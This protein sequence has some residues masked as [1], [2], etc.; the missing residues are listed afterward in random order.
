[1]HWFTNVVLLRK[2]T[3]ITA[4][5]CVLEKWVVVIRDDIPSALLCIG[6]SIMYKGATG[7]QNGEC[8]ETFQRY[9]HPQEYRRGSKRIHIRW[10]GK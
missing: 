5:V 1:M 2:K 6:Q 9:R 10:T 3:E 7:E 8:R 4:C